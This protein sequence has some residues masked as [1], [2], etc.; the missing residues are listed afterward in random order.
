MPTVTLTICENEDGSGVNCKADLNR[1][2]LET[3]P[4]LFAISI[5][6]TLKGME[7]TGGFDL[8]YAMWVPVDTAKPDADT[9]VLLGNENW[10][11]EVIQGSTDG[12]Q[13]FDMDGFLLEPAP[14]HWRQIP[15]LVV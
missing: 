12:E 3:Y 6:H 8:S 7:K 10:T 11:E 1:A 9:T 13:W 15:V 4:G 14:T 5:I 2:T